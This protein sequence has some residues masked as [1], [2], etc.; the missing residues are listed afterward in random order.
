MADG[1]PDRCRRSVVDDALLS[2]SVELQH[3]QQVCQG[4]HPTK[5][6]RLAGSGA[7]DLHAAP[8][9][10]IGVDSF[11]ARV[12]EREVEEGGSKHFTSTANGVPIESEWAT[13]ECGQL[14]SGL[15]LLADQVADACGDRG[16]DGVTR[17]V[18]GEDQALVV[19]A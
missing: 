14:S 16:V 13:R 19:Q 7:F 18:G 2:V 6:D 4:L 1:S 11:G 12:S 17:W 5:G 15:E 9:R 8:I 10:G 3:H